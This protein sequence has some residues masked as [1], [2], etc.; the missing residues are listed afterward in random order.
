VEVQVVSDRYLTLLQTLDATD[1]VN[2]RAQVRP[3]ESFSFFLSV[4]FS[5]TISFYFTFFYFV[6]AILCDY[7]YLAVVAFLFC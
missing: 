1:E 7:D 6:L 5:F 2:E 3:I 4:S